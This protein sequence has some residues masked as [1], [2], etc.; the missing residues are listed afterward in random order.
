MELKALKNHR[1]LLIFFWFFSFMQKMICVGTMP[2]SGYW[3]CRLGSKAKE[4]VYSNKCAVTA[5]LLTMFFMC[6]PG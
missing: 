4:V 2:L 3:K 1:W 5:L 6:P